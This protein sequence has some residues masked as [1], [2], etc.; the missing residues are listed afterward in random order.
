MKS[1][2]VIRKMDPVGRIVFPIELR[3]SLNLEDG[4]SLE[5][6]TEGEKIILKKYIPGCQCCNET[7]NLTTVYG[8]S[9]CPKCLDTFYKAS[10]KILK[11][12]K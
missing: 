8:I 1:L 3:R 12:D 10:S 9:L 5:I 7:E 4:D 2:G 6:F 11:G